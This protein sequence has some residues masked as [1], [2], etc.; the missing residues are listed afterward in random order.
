VLCTEVCTTPRVKAPV[1]KQARPGYLQSAARLEVMDVSCRGPIWPAECERPADRLGRQ[2]SQANGHK[3]GNFRTAVPRPNVT[4][5]Q[6]QIDSAPLQFT[7][8]STALTGRK[9]SAAFARG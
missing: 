4:Q 8:C 2:A 7:D 5:N 3:A 9:L 1:A 6:L